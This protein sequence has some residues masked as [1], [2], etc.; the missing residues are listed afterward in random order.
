MIDLAIAIAIFIVVIVV[1]IFIRIKFLK[2]T[3]VKQTDILIA[4]IP[5]VLWLFFSGR[6]EK[7]EFGD[8]KIQS[9]FLEASTTPI[10]GQITPLKFPVKMVSSN[11]KSAVSDI[12]RLINNKTEA[13][14]FNLSYGGYLDTAIEEYL[15]RLT[16]HAFFKYIVINS[17]DD[18]FVGMANARE[19]YTLFVKPDHEYDS[20]DFTN[21]LRR[22]DMNNLAKLPD[23]IG[24]ENAIQN[25]VDKQAVLEKMEKLNLEI[26]PVIDENG[27]FTGVVDRSR[28]TASL[29][30]DVANKVK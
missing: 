28:L 26:L 11:R 24:V 25:T 4:L 21:W 18:K 12:P 13:L 22:A 10:T 23:F 6:I 20:T 1:M 9:A 15:R 30:I 17:R 5:I 2:N 29:I 14:V 8:L 19:L 3:E 27:Q 7:F 16:Q